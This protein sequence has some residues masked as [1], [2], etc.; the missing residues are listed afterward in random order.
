MRGLRTLALG[1][2]IAVLAWQ[3]WNARNGRFVHPFLVSDVVVALLL[4]VAAV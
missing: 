4:V 3:G 1:F 2:G